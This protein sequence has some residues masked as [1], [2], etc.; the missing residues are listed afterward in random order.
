M[1]NHK[2]KFKFEIMK[3]NLLFVLAIFLATTMSAQLYV[4]A[5]LGYGLGANKYEAGTVMGDKTQSIEWG[6]MGQGLQIGG[7]VGY[8]FN[9]N[10]GFELGIDYFMSA[11][12]IIADV[13]VPTVVNINV[14]QDVKAKSNQ[15]RLLP[16]LVMKTD[17]GAYTRFGVIIPVMGKTV[18]T[19]HKEEVVMAPGPVKMTTD[20]EMEFSG[21]FSIGFAGALGY[22][23]ALS[24]NLKL[25]G[26]I[27]YTGLTI[28]GSSSSVTKYEVNGAD[29]LAAMTTIQ[30]ETTFVDELTATSNNT[31]YNASPDAAKAQDVLRSST[32]YSSYGFNVGVN[33]AF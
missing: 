7:K 21:K 18:V 23:Y 30:K 10:I 6:S 32:V 11:D 3:K 27:Q 20:A 4:G 12:G 9:D 31:T 2:L 33:F 24:D 17:M 5:K 13:N 28:R 26:E 14:I 1:I 19:S 8:F 16:Q 29:K 22:E 25:F 15:L